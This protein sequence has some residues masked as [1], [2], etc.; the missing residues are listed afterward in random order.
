MNDKIRR[1]N[2]LL[3]HGFSFKPV[4]TKNKL[5]KKQYSEIFKNFDYL[6]I[7]DSLKCRIENSTQI[8]F[9]WNVNIGIEQEFSNKNFIKLSNNDL[10]IFDNQS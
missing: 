6:K 8:P 7:F 10:D 4:N 5:L 2:N 3:G 1:E 9:E